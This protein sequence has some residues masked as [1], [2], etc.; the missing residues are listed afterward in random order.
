MTVLRTTSSGSRRRASGRRRA[1]RGLAVAVTVSSAV[2]LGVALR[3]ST[4]TPR[5]VTWDPLAQPA[6]EADT[7][8]LPDL[9]SPQ[10]ITAD[11]GFLS[12]DS[13]RTQ[14]QIA[15]NYEF[16]PGR[17]GPAVRAMP[18]TGGFVFYPVDGLLD[19]REFTLEYWT[20]ADQPWSAIDSGKATF[21][22]SGAV[23]GNHLR[24]LIPTGGQCGLTA[25]SQ[26]TVPGRAYHGSWTRPCDGLGLTG[27]AWHHIGLTLKDRKL[28]LYVDG[29]RVGGIDGVRFLPLWSDTTKEEGLQ[30]GGEPGAPGGI[31]V[32]D[33]RVSRTA[34]VPGRT[35]A[36][37]S[38]DGKV[39]VDSGEPTGEV[40]MK[41]VGA[42]KIWAADSLSPE[43]ARAGLATVREA[44]SVTDTPIKRGDPD[45]SHPSPGPSG[46]FSYDWQVVDRTF[47]WIKARGLEGYIGLDSTPQILGGSE[48][49]N[50]QHPT[51][52]GT[53]TSQLPAS[54]EDFAA[55]V[56]DLV[57]HAKASDDVVSQ[58]SLWN[59]P[60][61]PGA[62]WSGTLKQYLDL[63]AV[64]APAVKAADPSA[65]VGA[66]ESV[67]LNPTWLK[68]VFARARRDNLP[69]D[70]VSY[71]DYSGDLT[72]IARARATVDYYARRNGYP[73]PF[74]ISVSEYNWSDRND[75][76]GNLWFR[77]GFWH[78]R[79][80]NAAYMVASLIQAVEQKAFTTM[81]FS[82]ATGQYGSIRSGLKYS[83]ML[84]VGPRGE[85]Y[86]PYNALKG[87]KETVG[88][89]V[90][91]SAR[92][93]PPGIFNLNTRDPA[94]GKVGIVFA[95]Y[96]FAQRDTRKVDVSLVNLP[97][98]SYRLRRS[99]VDERHS[100]RWDIA[101]DRP[102]GA[103]QNDLQTVEDRVVDVSGT[104]NVSVSLP[105]WS[106]TFITLQPTG[107]NA[108]AAS[109]D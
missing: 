63:Y 94:T 29:K 38:L 81:V 8:F 39:S 41:L 61:L 4:G 100:S 59:E 95:S 103:S 55:I 91:D 6:H 16:G 107:R 33:V 87:W 99:I 76:A 80:F 90:L 64:V 86:A 50:A 106:S 92:D 7:L 58:W 74:P 73:T 102:E 78:L 2:A 14:E 105:R 54:F 26:E 36:I 40:P 51:F 60:D 97:V 89:E 67:Q 62:F 85:Q 88:P 82:H 12:G 68:A 56:S 10:A 52:G 44:G 101:E 45:P 71:H 84:L 1:R 15:A 53:Y 42:L 93:L 35:L 43:Q 30:L 19:G 22:V 49:P 25:S 108:Q 109:G 83:T 13:S 3:T 5:T 28:R 17:F 66:P 46:K 18:G 57:R 31:W 34:R 77:G 98:G 65:K 75:E 21:G 37:H 96:G 69:L 47:A 104:T 27:N 11:G 23:G 48:P 24:I 32:S 70:F 20:K 72:N 9:S 79:S